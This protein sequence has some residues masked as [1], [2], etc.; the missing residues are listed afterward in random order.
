M[1]TPAE[2]RGLVESI[3]D[4]VSFYKV[5]LQLFVGP[6]MRFV[7]ELVDAG[8]KVFL[9]LKIDDTPRTVSAAVRRAAI[10]GV[11]FFTLQGNRD[12][13]IAAIEGRGSRTTPKFLQITFLS[14]WDTADLK[15]HVG[16]P[17]SADITIDRAVLNRTRM[18][19]GAGCDGVI[20]SGQSVAEI[21]QRFGKDVLIVTPGIRPG[22]ASTDDH[23]RS[24][25]PRE[26]ILAGSD[27]LV[28]GRPV[29]NAADPGRTAR[30]VVAEIEA[31]LG[32]SS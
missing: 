9:D 27:Y 7:E 11:E 19:L 6:G 12:T 20:A 23:K 25:T 21:R 32:D 10:D 4:A 24:L 18:T 8:K 13:A 2:A 28:V 26:A 29:R 15:A 22:G 14:S 3:G 31:A 17:E 16:L 30:S 5:G 1:D